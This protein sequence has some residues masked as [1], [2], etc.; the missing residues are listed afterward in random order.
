MYNK[1]AIIITKYWLFCV[2]YLYLRHHKQFINKSF[3]K[4]KKSLYNFFSLLLLL[5]FLGICTQTYADEINLTTSYVTSSTSTEQFAMRIKAP[6]GT[7]YYID[8]GDGTEI[9]TKKGSGYGDYIYYNFADMATNPVH[10]VKIWGGPIVEFMVISNKKVSE[11]TLKDCNELVKFSCAN[12]DLKTLD[13]SACPKLT[14]V[15]CNANNIEDLKLPESAIYLTFQLNRLTLAEFPAKKSYK[16]VYGPM[17]P[18]Y[19]EKEKINGLT[20]DLTDFLQY[21]GTTST[22][23]WYRFNNHGNDGDFNMLIDPS[24]YK[25]ENGV[26]TFN[27]PFDTEIYCVVSNSALPRLDNINDRYGIMPIKLEG[28]AKQLEQ[29]HAAFLTDKFTTE[30]LTFNLTLSSLTDNS[31]CMIN[32]GDGVIQELKLNKTESVVKHNFI[33]AQVDK[34]HLVQIQCAD[35]DLLQFP[36]LSG[37]LAF[38]AGNVESP[39]KRI[40]LS[41]NRQNAIDVSMFKQLEALTA[42]SCFATEVKLPQTATLKQLSLEGNQLK[43]IDL[44]GFVNMEELNL[45]RN[46]LQAVNLSKMNKLVKVNLSFNNIYTFTMP[47][48]Y[49]L[50]KEMNCGNNSI[51]M[52]SLPEK[53]TI[54]TYV[55]A[56]QNSYTILPEYIK[57][58]VVDL[59]VFNNL[60]GVCDTP[61]PTTYIWL[62]KDETGIPIVKGLCYDEADGKFTFKLPEQADIYCSMQ[63]N[64]FP[65]LSSNG[66][67]YRTKPITMMKVANGIADIN[68]NEQ[69][70][71][72]VQHGSEITLISSKTAMVSIYD[73]QGRVAKNVNMTAGETA[74][75]TLPAGVYIMKANGMNTIKFVVK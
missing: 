58:N 36:E 19:L 56:P 68:G 5:S 46:Q 16:Y 70:I 14:D 66:V 11:L 28:K 38:Q 32:W 65:D 63:T 8:F 27:E 13:L 44:D 31:P 10:H 30:N 59:S 75:I 35:L 37:F 49:A 2:F 71:E 67:D 42:N 45:S 22:F 61:Q 62:N 29:V 34:K 6:S 15:T 64:A 3:I 18:V 57:K 48:T 60:K 54:E 24:T 53:K 73:V 9:Q 26:F 41:S 33:D 20:V 43:T 17:R 1:V 50:L 39:V 21:N 69:G 23:K 72:M 47:D 40:V 55:Y 7:K 25:E 74:N 51:P 4:M 52:Y 12:S